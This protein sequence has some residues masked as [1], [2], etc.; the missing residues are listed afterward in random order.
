VAVTR[1]AG[2]NTSG[3][4]EEAVAIDIGHHAP[5]SALD[6]QRVGARQ[7]WGDDLPIYL[8]QSARLWTGQISDDVWV[9][10]LDF[11]LS[12]VSFHFSQFSVQ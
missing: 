1:R 2:S 8:N 11:W 5:Q 7:G 12:I 6:R 4:V 3:E 9:S 10:G